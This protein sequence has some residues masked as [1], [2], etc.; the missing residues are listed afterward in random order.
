[1][2]NALRSIYQLIP[3]KGPVFKLLK[4]VWKPKESVYKHLHFKGIIN[5]QIEKGSRFKMHHVGH[6]I[7]NE[8]FWDGIEN[9]WEKLSIGLW[10]QLSKKANVILDIGAYSGLY[11]LTSAALNPEARV[12]SFEPMEH[13]FRLFNR[14]I[15]LNQFNTIVPVQKACSNFTDKAIV[16]TKKN[17]TLTT[18]VTVNK[19]LFDSNKDLEVVPIETIRLE[20]YYKQEG[21]EGLDLIKI[22]VETHEYEVLQGMGDLIRQYKPTFLIEVLNDDVAKNIESILNGLGYLYFDIDELSEIKQ[23]THIRK[24]SYYNYLVCQESVA[25]DLQLI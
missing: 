24:S 4:Q 18:S 6:Q 21:I 22:D 1:M 19:S 12:Y 8:L 3:F 25:K 20:D 14:N 2:R 9:A 13:N 16:Y 10:I 7:E 17:T 11:S 23:V 15:R 5:V